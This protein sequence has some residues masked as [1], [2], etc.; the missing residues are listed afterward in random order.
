MRV[1]R[2]GLVYSTEIWPEAVSDGLTL[3]CGDCGIVPRFDY[4]VDDDFWEKW[5]S[6]QNRR[7]VICLPCLDKRC[8]GAGLAEAL[9]E[10]QWTGTG[11]T[12]VCESVQAVEYHEDE[13][14]G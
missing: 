2:G 8:G 1:I 6:D 5:V 4:R 7:G 14:G 10:I 13:R 3:P 9:L 11:H 12:V